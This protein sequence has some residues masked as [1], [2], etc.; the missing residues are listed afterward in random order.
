[1]LACLFS[2]RHNLAKQELL[3]AG[4]QA[5]FIDVPIAGQRPPDNVYGHHYQISSAGM[6]VFQ[7]LAQVLEA[8][9]IPNQAKDIS[10]TDFH[11]LM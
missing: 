9:V 5:L 2:K 3:I 6:S 7:S 8:I 11:C 10:R 4:K 1:M